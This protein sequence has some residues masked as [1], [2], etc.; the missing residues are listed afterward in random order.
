MHNAYNPSIFDL[1]GKVAV[2]TGGGR[3]VG[4]SITLGLAGFGADIAICFQQN[5]DAARSVIEEVQSMGRCGFYSKA[6]ASS[7]DDIT[8]F[9][10]EVN[11]KMGKIDI[12]VNNVGGASPTAALEVKE[13]EWARLIDTNIKSTFFCSQAAAK[14]MIKRNQ[15]GKIINVASIA[16]LRS[17]LGRSVYA[18]A[19]GGVVQLTRALAIEWVEYGINVNAVA[20]G[21]L[22]TDATQH[23]FEPDSAFYQWILSKTPQKRV[24]NPDEV[25][26][27]VVLLASSASNAITGQII[28]VDGGWTAW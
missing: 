26:G 1:S 4:R 19:K 3:G 10:D 28:C 14:L 24:L 11:E 15:G 7:L 2:I 13:E 6:D 22:N 17:L 8:R 5:L 27:T 23:L 9:F 12:L 20:P 16:G 25:I 18:T 21:Y